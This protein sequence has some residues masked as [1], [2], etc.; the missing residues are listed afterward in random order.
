MI[1]F[2]FWGIQIEAAG[3][4]GQSLAAC[5]AILVICLILRQSAK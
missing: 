3:L 5:I 4:Y 2:N 1:K